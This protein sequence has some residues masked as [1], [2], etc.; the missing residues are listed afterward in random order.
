VRDAGRALWNHG[1]SADDLTQ[2]GIAFLPAPAS[3]YFEGVVDE[4]ADRKVSRLVV[5]QAPG[6]FARAV[7]DGARAQAS[8]RGIDGQVIE[9]SAVEGEDP[10]ASGRC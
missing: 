8:E 1:G 3:S 5:V 6:P 9:A 7:A 4:A 2:P 10:V